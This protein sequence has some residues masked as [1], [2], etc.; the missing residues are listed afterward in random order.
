MEDKVKLEFR[1]GTAPA[2]HTGV[3]GRS[4]PC[5]TLCSSLSTQ[6]SSS[7]NPS[8]GAG[9]AEVLRMLG[10][11]EDGVHEDSETELE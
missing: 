11:G 1:T 7:V 8:T 4:S 9:L 10:V 3:Y 2:I 5:N 6:T